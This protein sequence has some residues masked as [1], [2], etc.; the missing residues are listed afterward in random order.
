MLPTGYRYASIGLSLTLYLTPFCA[1]AAEFTVPT[2]DLRLFIVG[3]ITE[4]DYDRF[5]AAVREYRST[6]S[7][8]E[9]RSPG[10]RVRKPSK[11]E[12]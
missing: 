1:S 6:I 7:G 4:G 2:G 10:G 5:K 8:V 12:N 11:L 3:A 9:L